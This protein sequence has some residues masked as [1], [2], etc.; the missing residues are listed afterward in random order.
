MNADA[1]SGGG[2]AMILSW[3]GIAGFAWPWLLLA[4]P[5]PLLPRWLL[6]PVRSRDTALRV[7]YG[8]RL[9]TLAVHRPAPPKS[10]GLGPLW[11]WL[12][13]C[14]LCVAAAR[15]QQMGEV[16][17]PPRPARDMMLA[18]DLSGSMRE[19]DMQYR[20]RPANRLTVAK[21]VISDFLDRRSGDRVGLIVFGDRAYAMAPLTRDLETVREQLLGASIGLAG[22]GTAIGDAIALAAKRLRDQPADQRVLILI[23]D[24]VSS[25]GTYDPI[26]AAQLARDVGVRIHTIGLGGGSSLS[27]I[28]ITLP[29][30]SSGLPFDEATLKEISRITGGRSFAARDIEQ[31]AGIYAELDRLEPTT[32]QGERLRPKIE[33]YPWPLTVALILALCAAISTWRRG[34]VRA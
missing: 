7:P 29:L 19:P 6:P 22:D 30:P 32:V 8:G 9:E 18:V 15:P 2:L 4:L 3:M 5:L 27:V 34:R 23:T 21:A 11:W 1:A 12:A 31:L 16:T 13:W 10:S 25:P 17:Q 20:G 33:R 26:D 24:G 28:G 14:A